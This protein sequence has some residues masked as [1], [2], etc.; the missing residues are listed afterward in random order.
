MDEHQPPAEISA[1]RLPEKDALPL[2][3]TVRISTAKLNSILVQAEEMLSA[4]LALGQRVAELR[5]TSALLAS[6]EREQAKIQPELRTLLRGLERKEKGNGTRSQA[7]GRGGAATGIAK[8]AG[9]FPDDR[10]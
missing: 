3:E 7:D 5:E 9:F 8:I 4:K 2:P 6:W 10:A 1:P